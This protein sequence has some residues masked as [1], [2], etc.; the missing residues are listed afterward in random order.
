[1]L[2]YLHAY[3][4]FYFSIRSGNWLLRNSC[5]KV[6]TELFFAYSRDKYEVLSIS[7]LSDSYKYPKEVIDF[8]MNGQWTVSV[9]GRPFHNLALDKAH[10]CIINRK[11]K[12]ITT[13]ASHFRMV[14]L[15]DFMAYLDEVVTGL[16]SHVFKKHKH[17]VLNKK[18]DSTRAK[19]LYRLMNDKGLFSNVSDEK[20]LSNIFID[21]P[22]NLAAAN[23]ED[24]LN[25][26]SKGNERMFSYIRQYA[27][28]PPT[29]I[30]QKDVDKN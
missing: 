30:K 12:Q 25:I 20:P 24:L 6:L 13:R 5:L 2:I 10:E 16:D 17:K 18:K 27:L 19:I 22:P 9:K 4:G 26:H 11:L 7:A 23:S 15:S 28:E 8:F 1:M 3:S 29:E 14:E 21:N